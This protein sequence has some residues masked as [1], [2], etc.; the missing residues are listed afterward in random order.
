MGANLDFNT[1]N[2]LQLVGNITRRKITKNVGGLFWCRGN[3]FISVDFAVC[4]F[5]EYFTIT[6]KASETLYSLFTLIVIN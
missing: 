3:K 6:K 2:C 4:L 1:E 5:A